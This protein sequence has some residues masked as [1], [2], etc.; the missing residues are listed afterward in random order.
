MTVVHWSCANHD[1]ARVIFHMHPQTEQSDTV[2]SWRNLAFFWNRVKG[3][4]GWAVPCLSS[5]CSACH[6]RLLPFTV[7]LAL[8]GS[9]IF[10]LFSTAFRQMDPFEATPRFPFAVFWNCRSI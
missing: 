1:Y 6:L 8:L 10:A 4:E 7:D 2:R 3:F 9:L 5:L